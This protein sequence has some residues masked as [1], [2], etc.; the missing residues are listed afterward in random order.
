MPTI[1]LADD[2]NVQD[3]LLFHFQYYDKYTQS[4]DA[5]RQYGSTLRG[6]NIDMGEN[7]TVDA[8]S[9][10]GAQACVIED[11]VI[12]GNFKVGVHGIPGSGGSINGLKVIGGEIGILCDE[13]RPNPVLVGIELEGQNSC[14]VKITN[15][16]GPVCLVGFNITSQVNPSPSY[17]AVYAK[18][19]DNDSANP[20]GDLVLI[21]GQI[22]V[23]GAAGLAVYNY[24][25]NVTMRNVYIKA[26]RMVVD[27]LGTL[28]GDASKFFHIPS[29][30]YAT[31]VTEATVVRDSVDWHAAEPQDDYSEHE[32]IVEKEPPADLIERHLPGTF[33]SWEDNNLYDVVDRWWIHVTPDDPSDDDAVGIQEAI[34]FV[35]GSNWLKTV[36]LPRGHYHLKSGIT[37]KAGVNLIGAAKNLSVL[38]VDESLPQ[39]TPITV[40]ETE[41][42]EGTIRIG[43]LAIHS[44]MGDEASNFKNVTLLKVQT[45][46]TILKDFIIT[47]YNTE[48]TNQVVVGEPQ[49]RFAGHAGGRV[50]NLC[51]YRF[52][53]T[54][55]Q[56][57]YED[58]RLLDIEGTYFPLYFYSPSIEH[59]R[60]GPPA[61]EINGSENIHIVGMKTE[62]NKLLSLNNTMNFSMFGLSGNI[63]PH[64][65][66]GSDIIDISGN[67]DRIWLSTLD[68]KHSIA[69]N[70]NY[71]ITSPTEAV[72]DTLPVALYQKGDVSRMAPGMTENFDDAQSL[73]SNVN[74]V[75]F[76]YNLGELCYAG[77]AGWTVTCPSDRLQGVNYEVGVDLCMDQIPG[78]SWATP[79]LIFKSVDND[80]DY[81]ARI[82][83]NGNLLIEGPGGLKIEGNVS[84]L[85]SDP[86]NPVTAWNNLAVQVHSGNAEFLINGVKAS[87]VNGSLMIANDPGLEIAGDFGLIGRN[88]MASRF[89]NFFYYGLE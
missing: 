50:Y 28:A 75:N 70:D 61:I 6:F 58:F 22:T 67:S 53:V 76:F 55:S 45:S 32:P 15:S 84:S 35:A 66:E 63:V 62:G 24:R 38:H 42:T 33:P 81:T 64:S 54:S 23:N 47:K 73:F 8:I 4:P 57:G 27:Y 83:S 7:P 43:D 10:D 36:F 89:D 69:E 19:Y 25:Q 48:P 85:L 12:S 2:S 71:W 37:L 11:V 39:S 5:S 46:N 13:Y 88:G 1:K 78:A 41:D 59:C 30:V 74:G 16:R 26:E 82:K 14:G 34:D 9:M 77:T 44:A 49:V 52:V 31:A 80:S 29:F 21:D 87:S 79:T 20:R 72:T 86:L 60:H 3:N 18:T 68:R 56:A 40:V 51:Q 17:R 65:E